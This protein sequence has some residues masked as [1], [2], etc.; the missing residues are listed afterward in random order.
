MRKIITLIL[1]L[2]SGCFA[3][4]TENDWVGIS[5][6]LLSN[7]L[8]WS[9]LHYP[10]ASDSVVFGHVANAFKCSVDVINDSM[11]SLNILPAYTGIFAVGA[12]DTLTW[13]GYFYTIGSGTG[14]N[15]IPDTSVVI[16]MV[17]DGKIQFL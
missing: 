13:T 17:N 11:G 7:S 14:G 16:K 15:F 4:L 1:F 9:A 2:I 3:V 6:G 12:I 10:I 5:D 8:N